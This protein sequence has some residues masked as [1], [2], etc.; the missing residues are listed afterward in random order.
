MISSGLWGGVDISANAKVN[1]I[2]HEA[3]TMLVPEK[4]KK[5]II[6]TGSILRNRHSSPYW[7]NVV[8]HIS[9]GQGQSRRRMKGASRTKAEADVQREWRWA[10]NE[11]WAK[12]SDSLDAAAAECAIKIYSQCRGLYLDISTW[13]GGYN[14]Q[15]MPTELFYLQRTRQ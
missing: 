4:E 1:C 14:S 6:R 13:G 2:I 8:R 5:K 7:P 10:H 3:C 11:F 9:A 15:C 12:V